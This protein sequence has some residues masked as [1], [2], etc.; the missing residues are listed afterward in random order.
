[1]EEKPTLQDLLAPGKALSVLPGCP[2]KLV[3]PHLVLWSCWS[4][5]A[6]ER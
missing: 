4:S 3:D 6:R 5:P 1:M 2:M